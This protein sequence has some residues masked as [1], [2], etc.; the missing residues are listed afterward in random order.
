MLNAWMDFND[1][2]DWADAFEHIFIN[3]GLS[4]GPNNL[5][6]QIPPMA[7]AD[8]TFAR[9]RFS[10]LPS[11]SYDG[12][13]PNGEVE[14]YMVVIKAGEGQKWIQ[15]PDTNW[16][17]LHCHDAQIPGGPYQEIIIVRGNNPCR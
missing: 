3:V 8:T 13:A 17:G 6:F 4:A 2:G 7:V 10:T 15:L 1:D 11:L 5:T 16:P 12:S 14:D 9:F